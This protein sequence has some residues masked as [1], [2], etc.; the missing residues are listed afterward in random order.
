MQMTG[1]S[2]L[3]ETSVARDS[4]NIRRILAAIDF[5]AQTPQ[6]LE[7][8]LAF[9]RQFNAQ[10]FFVH[11]IYNPSTNLPPLDQATALTEGRRK[12]RET[13]ASRMSIN[14][15]SHTE[16]VSAERPELLVGHLVKKEHIDL[17]IVGSH[18]TSG[19]ERLA[20]GSVAENILRRATCPTLI[21]GPHA[22]VSGTPFRRILFATDLSAPSEHAVHLANLAAAQQEGQLTFLHVFRRASSSMYEVEKAK[23][24]ERMRELFSAASADACAVEFCVEPGRAGELIPQI[25]ANGHADLIVMGIAE[26]TSE[27]TLTPWSTFAEVV[28][29]AVCPVLAV[30]M[31]RQ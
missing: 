7:S 2:Y 1:D 12:L 19:M 27:N 28:H 20:F 31:A 6:V 18:G 26:R 13:L 25:A 29:A 16:I 15:C 8:V 23:L 10:V 5:S 14:T 3:A 17:V 24:L 9:A 4:W 30:R 11:S 21:V 22:K